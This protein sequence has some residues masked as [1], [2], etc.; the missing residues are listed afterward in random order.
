MS[1]TLLCQLII[2]IT[3]SS[4]SGAPSGFPASGNGLRYTSPGIRWVTDWLPVG[5]GYL[6]GES[7][8]CSLRLEL[9][10]TMHVES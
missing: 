10:L 7:D 8:F 6:G 9:H 3:I 1:N 2:G 5:N 4:V